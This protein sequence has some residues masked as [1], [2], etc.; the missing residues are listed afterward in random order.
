MTRRGMNHMKE[1]SAVF[2][3]ARQSAEA[4]RRLTLWCSLLTT[5]LRLGEEAS[6]T[7]VQLSSQRLLPYRRNGSLENTTEAD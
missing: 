7:A 3:E 1:S 5:R 4:L 2:N 6:D